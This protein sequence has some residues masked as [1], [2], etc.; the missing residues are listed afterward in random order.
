MKKIYLFGV[1]S[2][3]YKTGELKKVSELSPQCIAWKT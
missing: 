3:V 2:S 1:F